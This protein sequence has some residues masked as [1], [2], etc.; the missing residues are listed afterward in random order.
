MMTRMSVS[1]YSG[2]RYDLMESDD[3][4][5]KR[6]KMYTTSKLLLAQNQKYLAVALGPTITFMQGYGLK[7][8]FKKREKSKRYN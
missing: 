3:R 2:A 1:K 4:M 7:K 5:D 6:Y 8:S